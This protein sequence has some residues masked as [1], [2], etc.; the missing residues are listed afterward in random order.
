MNYISNLNIDYLTSCNPQIFNK[1]T[2]KNH[3]P[4]KVIDEKLKEETK[5]INIKTYTYDTIINNIFNTTKFISPWES[6]I[7]PSLSEYFKNL[8]KKLIN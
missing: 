7:L 2:F 3:I 6:S 4:I 8:R 1:L 5:I